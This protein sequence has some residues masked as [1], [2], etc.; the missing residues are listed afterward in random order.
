MSEDTNVHSHE[1]KRLR[2]EFATLIFAG[3]TMIAVLIY[4]GVTISEWKEM[5]QSMVISQRAWVGPSGP[6]VINSLDL[7]P[8]TAKVSFSIAIK[9]FGQS[10]AVHVVP[11]AEVTFAA[12]KLDATVKET[13]DNAISISNGVFLDSQAAFNGI[14]REV[15]PDRPFGN[16]LFPNQETPTTFTGYV[17]SKPDAKLMWIIGCIAYRDQFGNERRTRFCYAPEQSPDDSNYPNGVNPRDLKLPAR[18]A[19]CNSYNDVE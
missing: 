15:R 13:C 11:W 12:D 18:T 19:S 6:P 10:V 7:G 16:I 4:T 2:I 1:Q 5:H 3:L 9:D 8:P 17:N 14:H